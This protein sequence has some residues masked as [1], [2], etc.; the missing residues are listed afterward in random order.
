MAEALCNKSE[1]RGLIPDAF[2]GFL[3][4]PNPSS[5]TMALGSTNPLTGMNT[6]NHPGGKGRTESKAD[7]LTDSY[8][9]IV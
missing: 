2:I 5:R 9:P 3:N 4:W 6:K 8:E 7:N 1:S